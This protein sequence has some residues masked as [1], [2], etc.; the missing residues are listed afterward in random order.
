MGP[1][2]NDSASAANHWKYGFAPL[3]HI[4]S[5]G[6]A[7]AA[8]FTAGMYFWSSFRHPWKP[9][10]AE[11]MGFLALWPDQQQYLKSTLAFVRGDLDPLQHYYFPGFSLLGVPFTKL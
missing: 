9:T 4:E 6:I 7:L 1:G 3:R 11:D 2:A 8:I 5:I 10:S